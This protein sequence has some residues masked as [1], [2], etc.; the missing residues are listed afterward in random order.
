MVHLTLDDIQ[1]CFC[2]VEHG[3]RTIQFNGTNAHLYPAHPFSPSSS[4]STH[5]DG[6]NDTATCYPWWAVTNLRPAGSND[7]ANSSNI[8]YS[9]AG[10]GGEFV[11]LPMHAVEDALY[12]RVA[13]AVCSFGL[14]G[15]V[16]NLVV[17]AA[18]ARRTARAPSSPG[19][20]AGGRMHRF[21]AIGLAA[22]AVSDA[23][24]C[25]AV[26]PRGFVERDPISA[27]FNFSLAYAAYGEAFI[28]IF[29]A[30]STWLTIAMALGRYLA[31]CHPFRAREVI[32]CTVA[33]RAIVAIFAGCVG[34]NL[35]RF[36]WNDVASATSC[37]GR[38]LYFRW[39]GAVHRATHP[40]AERAY[41]WTYF[42]VALCLPLALLLWSS[43]YM[44]RKLRRTRRTRLLIG[45]TSSSSTTTPTVT[46]GATGSCIVD[47]MPTALPPEALVDGPFTVTL[48]AIAVMHVVLVSPAELLS[49]ARQMASTADDDDHD[50]YN[51]TAAVFNTMQAT[52][53]SVNFVLYL[54]VNSSFRRLFVELVRC[55]AWRANGNAAR[56]RRRRHGGSGISRG[57]GSDVTVRCQDSELHPVVAA[58]TESLSVDRT[59]S[60]RRQQRQQQRRRRSRDRAANCLA[61]R[62]YVSV[63]EPGNL[64][65]QE[66][67]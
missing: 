55:R 16:A 22:L 31:I 1:D 36:W 5:R 25:A 21:A 41:F 29:V 6:G 13:V 56:G 38:R 19:I 32:G 49:F 12:R 63:R 48:I 65:P 26:L 60:D 58:E 42:V 24:F 15:N 35:P 23:L 44:I 61:L 39:P 53:S 3:R 10:G 30:A 2:I 57:G 52:N 43:A 33:R 45:G 50:A 27:S 14:L 37:T 17:L 47:G 9:G 40:G 18:Q 20:G 66:D 4:S 64:T 28:N 54:A 59:S 7:S 34:A 62:H 67:N 11:Q 51:L 46:N 8:T